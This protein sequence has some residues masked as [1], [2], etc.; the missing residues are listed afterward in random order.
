MVSVFIDFADAFGSVEHEFIFETLESFDIPLT[1]C[2]LIED[3]Y[4]YSS[5]SVICGCELSELFYM[6]RGTKTGDPLSALIFILVIDV[7]CRPMYRRALD[8]MNILNDEIINPLPVQAFADDINTTHHDAK[9]IQR[10]SM[11]A[12]KSVFSQ[13]SKLNPRN[14][15]LS[16]HD[17]LIIIGTKEKMT[18][19]R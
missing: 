12:K 15:L 3:I 7:V 13:D 18:S 4:R 9:L 14:V 5:S 6:I 11:S 17:A 10:C 19:L 2:A 8:E 1:Y 16:T